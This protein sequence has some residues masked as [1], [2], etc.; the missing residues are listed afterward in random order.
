MALARSIAMKYVLGRKVLARKHLETKKCLLKHIYKGYRIA[1][2]VGMPLLVH[3][4][5]PGGLGTLEGTAESGSEEAA[6][7][8]EAR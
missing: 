2:A 3:V 7:A 5:C 6:G 1:Q 8:A 4:P